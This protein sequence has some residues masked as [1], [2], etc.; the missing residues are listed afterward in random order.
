MANKTLSILALLLS[1]IAISLSGFALVKV[2]APLSPDAFE[3]V[4]QEPAA[5]EAVP[6]DIDGRSP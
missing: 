2:T 5:G 6:S 4:S 3:H 1:A